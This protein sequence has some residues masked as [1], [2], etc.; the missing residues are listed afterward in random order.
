MKKTIVIGLDGFE[1]TLLERWRDKLPNL[2]NLMKE[3]VY[4]RLR[5]TTPL[6]SGPSWTTFTTGKNPWNHGVYDLYHKENTELITADEV[7]SARI[8][9]YLNDSGFKTGIVNLAVTYPPEKI[10]G[11]MI[12][13]FLAPSNSKSF[14]HPVELRE[15]L[16]NERPEFEITGEVDEAG[17]EKSL[18]SIRE[19]TKQRKENVLWLMENKEWDFFS[20]N[21]RGT[22]KIAHK[23]WHLIDETHPD[24]RED[25]SEKFENAYLDYY[26]YID[27]CVGEFLENVPEGSNVFVISDHGTGSVYDSEGPFKHAKIE[28]LKLFLKSNWTERKKLLS[29]VVNKF[30]PSPGSSKKKN[31]V[32]I[33]TGEHRFYGT[34]IAF[35]PDIKGRVKVENPGIV[36]LAPTFLYMYGLPV[37]RD[38][39]GRVLRE[40]FGEKALKTKDSIKY[41][42]P[43]EFQKEF[44]E[45]EIIEKDEEKVKERLKDLG[46]L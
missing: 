44:V 1:P 28:L 5:S 17:V 26:R 42:E 12:S 32:P 41:R 4:S 9:D 19:T 43:K 8:W 33:T 38:M 6:G 15:K 18:E 21:L 14:T 30:L 39:D 10:D 34:F 31:E 25:L 36:D 27:E 11:F 29:E 46:Y 24:Y 20:F 16:P 3:G 45:E 22:D 35:G 7:E 13:T 2:D 37:P 40:I 23:C